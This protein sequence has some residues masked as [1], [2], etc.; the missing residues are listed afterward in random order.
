MRLVLIS[1]LSLKT[2]L[3]CE[4]RFFYTFL[5][6]ALDPDITVESKFAETGP[7]ASDA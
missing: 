2:L 7:V 3:A 4:T 5:L 1:V 6:N